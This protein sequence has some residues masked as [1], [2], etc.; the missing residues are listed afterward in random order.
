MS[1]VQI[2]LIEFLDHSSS[3][4]SG[5]RVSSEILRPHVAL[6]QDGVNSRSDPRGMITQSGVVEHVSRGQQHP[7]R[8]CHVFPGHFLV[9][10]MS[11]LL[12]VKWG[13][14]YVP[15]ARL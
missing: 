7:G 12:A 3:K 6:R 10:G 9:E 2:H 4:L 15:N 8:V 1:P 5:S 11:K 14:T 13:H